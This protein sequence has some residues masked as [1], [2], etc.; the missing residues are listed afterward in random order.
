[1]DLLAGIRAF[2][3]VVEAGGFAAAGREMGLSRSVVNRQVIQLERHLG[4]QLLRRSTR[5][6]STTET[7]AVF[8]ERC[9]GVLSALD[10]AVAAVT[11]LQTKLTGNLRVNAPMSFVP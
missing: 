6:V 11:T 5:S 4:A 3:K 1:M 8:Y 2:T 10:E 7:G 9:I